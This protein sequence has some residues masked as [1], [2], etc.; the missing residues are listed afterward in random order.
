MEHQFA[1]AYIKLGNIETNL[2]PHDAPG[3]GDGGVPVAPQAVVSGQ[4][5]TRLSGEAGP[6]RRVDLKRVLEESKVISFKD[7]WARL[8]V[9]LYPSTPVKHQLSR[10]SGSN[11]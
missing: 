3:R 2:L 7:I 10:T 11:R 4:V 9:S 1:A 6:G 5:L 8:T